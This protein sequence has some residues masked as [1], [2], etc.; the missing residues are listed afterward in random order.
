[1]NSADIRAALRNCYKQ[2]EWA[3]FFE[4]ADGTGMN[5]RRTADGILMNMYPSRGLTV[6]GLEFKV[7]RSDWTRELRDPDKAESV[8]R[9]CDLWSVVAPKGLIAPAEMPRTWGLIEVDG[10]ATRVKVQASERKAAALD[11][12]FVA[13]LVRS[14]AK[15]DESVVNKMVDAQ[16]SAALSDR[17][18]R[19][20]AEVERRTR[21]A[22]E[23][24][25]KHAAFAAS[26]KKWNGLG[27]LK[28]DD[29]IRGLEIL[30][31]LG[32][33]KKYDGL[34]DV[35]NSIKSLAEKAE[36]IQRELKE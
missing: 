27:S 17:E 10:G 21:D 2:P 20:N 8:A 35:L 34:H 32:I 13:S 29:V 18:A 14:V 23:I 11:R 7:S 33:R 15:V 3:I 28:E 4:V 26:L 16:V 1:M 9:Y 25:E 19:I 36:A 22:K 30:D 6:H 24:V 5:K 31:E 12:S